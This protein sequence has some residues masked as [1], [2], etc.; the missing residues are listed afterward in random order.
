MIIHLIFDIF[1]LNYFISETES[2][3]FQKDT[4]QS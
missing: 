1:L 4:R 3:R 2:H